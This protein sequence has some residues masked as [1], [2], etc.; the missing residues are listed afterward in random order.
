MRLP[1]KLIKSGNL[2][3]IEVPMLAVTTQGRSKKE[4][5]AMI[6]D[7]IESLIDKEDFQVQVFPGADGYF[8]IGAKDI[9]ILI[10]FL[11]RRR[12][13]IQGLT[14]KEVAK[15]LDAKSINTYARYEQGRAV[16]SIATFDRLLCA[17]S[18]DGD[19]VLSESRIS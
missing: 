15:R 6:A 3:A 2:W 9:A 8:E 10:A 16:P 17:L 12:R 7:A 11:L 18:D 1:G 14:L 19:L 13:K 4:A 5:Y